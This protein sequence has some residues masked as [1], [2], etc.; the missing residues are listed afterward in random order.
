MA[1]RGIATAP[2]RADRTCVAGGLRRARAVRGRCVL[3]RST[4]EIHKR[5]DPRSIR[6]R[7][8][9]ASLLPKEALELVDHRLSVRKLLRRYV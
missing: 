2:T 3:A 7:L 9:V 8:R 1:S 6:G 4:S 5:P